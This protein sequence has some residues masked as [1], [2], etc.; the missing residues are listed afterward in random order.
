M[1]DNL[2]RLGGLVLS[3][4][5]MLR[6]GAA[7]G[8]NAAHDVVYEAAMAAWEGKGSFRDLL[9]ADS[10]VASTL[11]ASELDRLLDPAAYTGMAGAFVDR[12]LADARRLSG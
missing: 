5:V 7:L 3:E 2:D 4:P 10:R 1:R 12:V 9:L 11:S 8:R 6:L